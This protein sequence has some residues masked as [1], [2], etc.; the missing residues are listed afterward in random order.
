MT[1]DKIKT[2]CRFFRG[3]IPCKPHKNF[4]VHCESDSG[5]CGFYDSFDTKILIIKLGAIGDVI[6]TT[7]LLT[8]L[9]KEY[10]KSKI[11]WLTLTPSIL[12][13]L[14]DA[15][16]KMNFESVLFLRSFEFDIAINLDKDREACSLINRI[17]AREKKGYYLKDGIPA[18]IDEKAVAK[19][20]TGIFDDINKSNVKSYP[21]EIFEI[22]GYA[23]AGEKY[24]LSK[25]EEFSDLWQFEKDKKIIGLNTG[26]GGRWTSRL[27]PEKYWVTL[28]SSLINSGY[29]VV[30]LGGEQE[31]EKNRRLSA[32]TGGEYF[33]HFS[34]EKFINLVNQCHLVV[35]GVTMAMHITIALEKKIVL[36]NNIFNPREFELY[37]LGEIIQP[38]KECA[39]YFS[40]ACKN[41]EYKCMEHL[42]PERAYDAVKRL[43]PL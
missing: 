16:L 39:C 12:P 18:P 37:G 6:R 25:Y 30:F 2:D 24:I 7:P 15:P 4:N 11:F 41:T 23:F 19:Y 31:D 36:F 32:Q 20:M 26:C 33:G 42:E 8:R 9:K 3:D 22:C 28:A 34:L 38:S 40:A 43:L 1:F 14:V 35:T 5:I 29:T 17:A 27:W 13:P 10:P 21:E